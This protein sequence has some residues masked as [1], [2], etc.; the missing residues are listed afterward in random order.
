MKDFLNDIKVFLYG[1]NAI[2]RTPV[3]QIHS[4][5]N[6]RIALHYWK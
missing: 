3:L 5:K 4:L 2:V 1:D 6:P